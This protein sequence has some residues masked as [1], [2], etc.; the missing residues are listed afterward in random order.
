[1]LTIHFSLQCLEGT[2]FQFP[3]AMAAARASKKYDRVFNLQDA[4]RE[5]PNIAAYFESG[6]RQPFGPGVYRYYAELDLAPATDLE[7]DW[8]LD[9]MGLDLAELESRK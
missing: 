7:M 2:M 9:K 4:V 8:Q 1:M 5:R 6:R 3:K